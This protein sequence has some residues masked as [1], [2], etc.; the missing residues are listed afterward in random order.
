[1]RHIAQLFEV[2]MM[3]K[4]SYTT[5]L[6]LCVFHAVFFHVSLWA[7]NFKEFHRMR[8]PFIGHKVTAQFADSTLKQHAVNKCYFC[9]FNSF[10]S[11]KEGL[12][13]GGH[14]CAWPFYLSHVSPS[15]GNQSGVGWSSKANPLTAI[16][17]FLFIFFRLFTWSLCISSLLK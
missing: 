9:N 16:V 8:T 12:N 14:K 7:S 6:P 3:R 17:H 15:P 2:D 13:A 4:L 11:W 5:E 10:L 1:M